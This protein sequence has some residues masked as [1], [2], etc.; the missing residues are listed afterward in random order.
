[1]QHPLNVEPVLFSG[2]VRSVRTD[3]ATAIR[4]T[5]ILGI[6]L[7]DVINIAHGFGASHIAIFHYRVVVA[8]RLLQGQHKGS[9]IM[10]P[11]W[12]LAVFPCQSHGIPDVEKT[13]IV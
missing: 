3:R 11:M 10:P 12:V 8:G 4:H 2:T 7:P 13:A 1:M 5:T 6:A 9:H